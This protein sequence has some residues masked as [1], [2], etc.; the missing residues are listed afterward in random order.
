M[1]NKTCDFVKLSEELVSRSA[2]ALYESE[3]SFSCW[4]KSTTGCCHSQF[5]PDSTFTHF[6][7]FQFN[8]IHSSLPV[9]H[10]ISSFEIPVSQFYTRFSSVDHSHTPCHIQCIMMFLYCTFLCH[11]LHSSCLCFK[12]IHRHFILAHPYPLSVVKSYVISVPCP[13]NTTYF[14]I[15][16]QTDN[17]GWAVLIQNYK[18]CYLTTWSSSWCGLAPWPISYKQETGN[19]GNF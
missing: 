8:I 2:A 13:Y 10:M 5:I 6:F 7:K 19:W 15:N 9:S 16:N 3:G 12:H 4:R 11:P 14:L 18:S 1:T 17:L